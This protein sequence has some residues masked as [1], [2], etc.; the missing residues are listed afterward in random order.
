MSK[1]ALQLINENIEKHKRGKD[2][3]SLDLRDCGMTEIPLQIEECTWLESLK[4][5]YSYEN[6]GVFEK[7]LNVFDNGTRGKANKISRLEDRL[8]KL[9]NLKFLSFS[10]QNDISDISSL[11]GLTNLQILVCDFTQVRDLSPIAALT[12]LRE[13]Y[14]DSTPVSDLSPIAALTNLQLLDCQN[15]Q[16]DDLSSILP[17]IKSGRQVDWERSVGDICVK[18]C[19]LVNPPVEI[20]KQGN[21]AILEYFSRIEKEGAQELLEAKAILI[22]EG[23]AGKTS[24]RNRLLGRA[25]PTK[26]DRTKGLD[27]E[28]EPYRFPLADG[29][30]MQL[31]LFDF[32]GQ[33]HY[34]PLHQFFYSKRS[35]Y[36]LLT[37]NGDDQ[38]DFDFWLDTAKLH[39]DDSPLLVVNNLFGDVKC[40]FNPKQWTSQ[41]PFLKASFEVNLDNLNGLEDLKQK[42][43]AY[44]QTLPHI[45]QPVPKSWAAIREALREQKVKENFIHLTEYLRICREHGIEER[46]SAMHLSRYLHDIGVFLHFQDNETLR[47]W[48]IL[49]NEWATE[50]VYRVLD[51]SEIIAQKGHFAPSDLKRVWCAD[52]YE[53]MRDALLELM[54]EFRLCYPKPDG[55]RFIAP[56][57]LPTEPPAYNWQADADER[58]IRLEYVFMPRVLFTQ[59]V[60]A[61]HEKIENGR[62]CVWRSGAVFSKGTA[63][64]QVRQIGKN[65]LEFR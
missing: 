4:L 16:V 38:N 8:S 62:L 40:N 48:V 15:T 12:N 19:P 53:D 50:A 24:L 35:L 30:E 37:K 63:R 28:V 20:V 34:K 54:K 56:S 22:G 7:I 17:L 58:C 29:K 64:V 6:E 5:G 13:I 1:L 61:E 3:L 11:G 39:G 9:Q 36:L 27:V 26:S 41:Y 14:F 65:T 33:D 31:N 45:R 46:D 60:V 49:R 44:A 25:L 10:G 52:E 47:K 59:F 51:D 42:I 2:A 55:Q 32:G 21:E 23:M 57:L 18:G 43:E